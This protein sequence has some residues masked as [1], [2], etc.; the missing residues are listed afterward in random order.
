MS[1]QVNRTLGAAP[2]GETDEQRLAREFK[3]LA[4][5]RSVVSYGDPYLSFDASAEPALTDDLVANPKAHGSSIHVN[6]P[7]PTAAGAKS[8]SYG[9]LY[10]GR[11][12]NPLSAPIW[13]FHIYW[14]PNNLDEKEYARKLHAAIRREFPELHVKRFWEVAIGPHPTPM[15]EVNIFNTEELGALFSYVVENRGPLSVLIHPN[16]GESAGDHTTRATW[17][18]PKIEL[19]VAPLYAFDIRQKAAL[20]AKAA[21]NGAK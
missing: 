6:P 20:D 12:D 18:G 17:L 4:S 15:F 8:P 1:V 9:P 10:R 2:A 7:R 13:D 21:A 16:T 14:K 5:G 19:D 3:A 11:D